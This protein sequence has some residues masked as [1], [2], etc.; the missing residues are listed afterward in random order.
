MRTVHPLYLHFHELVYIKIKM[1]YILFAFLI[2][3]AH[4]KGNGLHDITGSVKKVR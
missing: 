1:D 2:E 4:T 3:L